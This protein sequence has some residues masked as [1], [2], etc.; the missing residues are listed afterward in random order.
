M[1]K[2]ISLI[3]ICTML[4]SLSL[5]AF[6]TNSVTQTAENEENSTALEP[7]VLYTAENGVRPNTKGLNSDGEYESNIGGEMVTKDGKMAFKMGPGY[8]AFKT[9][10]EIILA[11]TPDMHMEKYSDIV[12]EAYSAKSTLDPFYVRLYNS[13]K[14]NKE[15]TRTDFWQTNWKTNWEGEWKEIRIPF[16]GGWQ[17]RG[18]F[19]KGSLPLFEPYEAERLNITPQYTSFQEDTEIYIHKIYFDGERQED[20]VTSSGE[21]I[22]SDRYDPETMTDYAAKVKEKHPDKAHPR[23]FVNDEV[24]ERIKE[25][26]DTANTFMNKAY[27]KVKKTADNFLTEEPEPPYHMNE[28][29]TNHQ[30][31]RTIVDVAKNCGMMYLLTDD[32]DKKAE[33]AERIWA[34]V[35]NMAESD[36]LWS[37]ISSGYDC[38][39]I[40]F[41]MSLAYDWLYDYWTNDQ[42]IYIRNTLMK[43]SFPF[44]L[45]VR[46]GVGW[47]NSRNN[48]TALNSYGFMITSLAICDEAGYEDLCNELMNYIVK[49][50]PMNFM[51]QLEPDGG[52]GEGITYWRTSIYSFVCLTEAMLSAMDTDAGLMDH[53]AFRKTCYFPF[54]MRGSQG[55]FN[56]SDADKAAL[57]GGDAMY[58]VLDKRYDIPQ[59]SSYRLSN[60]TSVSIDDLLWFDPEADVL[61][62][63][64]EGLPKDYFFGGLE[65]T[66]T[67]RSSYETNCTYLGTKGGNSKTGHDHYDSGTFVLDALG[68]R[69]I[70][71][72]TRGLYGITSLPYDYYY[73]K[74]PEA[75][76]CIVFDPERGWIEGGGQTVATNSTDTI[77]PITD[78]ASSSGAAFTVFDLSP[79]YK[80]TT[81]SYKRGFALINNRTQFI[82]RDEFETTEPFELYSYF[83]T[84]KENEIIINSDGKSLIMKNKKS[85]EM[86]KVDFI[87]DIPSFEIGVMEAEKH[88]ASPVIPS[89]GNHVAD[90]D[91]SDYHKFYLRAD[92][93][94]KASITVVFTPLTANTSV[95]VPEIKPL[96]SWDDYVENS[97]ALEPYVLYTA[98]NGVRPNTSTKKG[99][100]MV[101]MDG[102]MAFKMG[103]GY[104]AFEAI[105][106]IR[107]AVTPDMHM[108]KYSDIVIEAYSAKSTLDPFPVRL[109]NTEK[110]NPET[111]NTDFWQT[112]WKTNWEGEWKEIRIPF[113]GGWQGR[114]DFEKGLLPLFEPYEADR[115]YI[116]PK[117]T[118][119]QSDTE[120]YIH[121]IYFDGEREDSTDATIYNIDINNITDNK[122]TITT[123]GTVTGEKTLILA[124]YSVTNSGTRLVGVKAVPVEFEKGTKSY[125][126]T[127]FDAGNGNIIK[128]FVWDDMLSTQPLSKPQSK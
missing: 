82:V 113:T 112:S 19:E 104:D 100:E 110:N 83:H 54:A 111:T 115:L 5:P 123:N 93:V 98:E 77:C 109:Y 59:L 89:D 20:T 38:G 117:Y 73:Y 31:N 106:E 53:P 44:A 71:N 127:G 60:H 13:T 86:C 116:A 35:V 90:R 39:Q 26:K 80:E 11:I 29:G 75:H 47:M 15:T 118:T 12:I 79:A 22:L 62:D 121:K 66:A 65:P 61:D 107:L 32:A 58:F 122:V 68:V 9:I 6:A 92:D 1:K 126:V 74:R 10:G 88:P 105:G 17:G 78:S 55:A 103:P 94:E 42:K 48:I 101:T 57:V 52:Y 7:Y 72:I 40:S 21:L 84:L 8:D 85:G 91:Y 41:A 4:L 67:M 128:A 97:T 81:S 63:W 51:H 43:H 3:V 125:T 33:Y 99:G 95:T 64:S 23:I 120:I 119:F 56:H 24:L 27:N 45:T 37:S 114:G 124:S 102:K 14:D 76:N 25:H 108:E 34:E 96:A 46:N 2:F 28:A 87:T 16:T 30:F 49:Y 36:K 50:L 69:W 70:E 18:D